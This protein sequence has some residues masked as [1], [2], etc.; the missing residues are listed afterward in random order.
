MQK[1]SV[2]ELLNTEIVL[3]IRARAKS[4]NKFARYL[5]L[6]NIFIVI[7]IIG[8]FFINPSIYRLNTN[9]ASKTTFEFVGFKYQVAKEILLP[10]DSNSKVAELTE[11]N[12]E[13]QHAANERAFLMKT[14]GDAILRFGSVLLAVYLIQILVNF[15]RYHFRVADHLESVAD[16]IELA[17]GELENMEKIFNILSSKHIEFGKSPSSAHENITEIIKESIAKIP[18]K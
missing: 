1:N 6:I 18:S 16:S 10:K 15:T 7:V 14:I 4:S 3:T 17:K 13:L 12:K 9:L 8:L 11:K 5:I 2:N